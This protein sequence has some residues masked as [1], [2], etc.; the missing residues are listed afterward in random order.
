MGEDERGVE[1]EVQVDEASDGQQ[2]KRKRRN[3]DQV[4]QDILFV[5]LS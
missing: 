1:G 5:P 3:V 2:K 4:D